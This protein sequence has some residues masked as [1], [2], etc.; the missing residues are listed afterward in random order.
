MDNNLLFMTIDN[1]NCE[2]LASK[3]LY[4]PRETTKA[5]TEAEKAGWKLAARE[6]RE[7]TKT[8]FPR[9]R[10]LLSFPSLSHALSRVRLLKRPGAITFKNSESVEESLLRTIASD[11]ASAKTTKTTT[12]SGKMSKAFSLSWA[13]Y[14]RSVDNVFASKR[15]CITNY[16][17][18]AEEDQRFARCVTRFFPLFFFI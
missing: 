14:L 18:L 5:E 17:G 13:R 4:C 8:N 16:E 1:I 3:S 11:T 9:F 2:S 6:I 7:R 12:K 15:A 10:T